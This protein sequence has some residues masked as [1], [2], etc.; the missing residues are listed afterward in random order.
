[1]CPENKLHRY[2]DDEVRIITVDLVRFLWSTRE[3][4]QT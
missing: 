4:R 2:E 3:Y 1:M